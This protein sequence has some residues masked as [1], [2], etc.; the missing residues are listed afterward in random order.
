M[1]TANLQN[2][3][4]TRVGLRQAGQSSSRAWNSLRLDQGLIPMPD[5]VRTTRLMRINGN[6]RIHVLHLPDP[7]AQIVNA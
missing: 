2:E 6:D 1:N 7:P 3:I 4:V 5:N